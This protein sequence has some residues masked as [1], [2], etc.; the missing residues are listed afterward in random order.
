[1]CW[2]TNDQWAKEAELRE[3]RRRDQ[4]THRVKVRKKQ[5]CSVKRHVRRLSWMRI[6]TKPVDCEADCPRKLE[7]GEKERS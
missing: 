3:L 4:K 2:R 5:Q 6:V 7:A 1:M